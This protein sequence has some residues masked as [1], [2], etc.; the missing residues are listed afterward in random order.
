MVEQ[1]ILYPSKAKNAQDL[2]AGWPD[3]PEYTFPGGA[4]IYYTGLDFDAAA[5]EAYFGQWH[6]L[7]NATREGTC[8]VDLHYCMTSAHTGTV[9][10]TLDLWTVSYNNDLASLNAPTVTTSWTIDPVDTAR[11]YDVNFYNIGYSGTVRGTRMGQFSMTSLGLSTIQNEVFY[12]LRR[13]ATDAINDTHT[14][15]ISIFRVEFHYPIS[16]YT[17][18]VGE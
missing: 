10:M 5:V 7:H 17:M 8:Y 14:G 2:G 4:G 13:N 9:S 15:D 1:I 11:Y 16:R 6:P 3:V 18:T 12:R